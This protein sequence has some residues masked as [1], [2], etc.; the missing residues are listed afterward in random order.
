MW[1]AFYVLSILLEK[2]RIL[3]RL[4]FIKLTLNS[5]NL[6]KNLNNYISGN[7]ESTKET[8]NILEMPGRILAVPTFYSVLGPGGFAGTWSNFAPGS[9]L[10]PE[11]Q[12]AV[13]FL[14]NNE[15][16]IYWSYKIRGV[17]R[18]LSRGGLTFFSLSRG[19]SAPVGAWK[20]PEINR[21]H[22]SRVGGLAPIASPLDTTLYKI[23]EF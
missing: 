19:D 10:V 9:R 23:F 22:W 6:N 5:G 20:P 12:E 2:L 11:L 14:T 18:N 15:C 16:I 4:Q 8:E 7:F 21:F 1:S 13:L 17:F 3:F